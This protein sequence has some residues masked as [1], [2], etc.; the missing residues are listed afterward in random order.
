LYYGKI[1]YKLVI[2][3]DLDY[4]NLMN[5][6]LLY[7]HKVNRDSASKV[8]CHFHDFWQLEIVT[9][10][11]IDAMI[12]GKCF[13]LNSRDM[14]L[15][16][17]GIEHGFVYNFPDISWISL[18]FS[19]AFTDSDTDT[20]TDTNTDTDT[21]NETLPVIDVDDY[22]VIRY[23]PFTGRLI[24]SLEAIVQNAILEDYEKI[25]IEGHIEAI[26]RYIHS[27]SYIH[28]ESVRS[29]IIDDITSFI[30]SCNGKPVTVNEIAKK[31]SYSRS[32][33]SKEFKQQT[34]Q[35]LKSYIDKTRLDKAKEMLLY[36]DFSISDIAFALGF[37]DVY[38]FSRFFKKHAASC[39]KIYR[40]NN[41]FYPSSNFN[42]F[43]QGIYQSY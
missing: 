19:A 22:T 42:T 29:T 4:N 9:G 36:S 1:H 18:K 13:A 27:D 21:G 24:A 8:N 25:V 10:G 7:V 43:L 28:P 3:C 26:L 38:S 30:K 15:I 37:K 14:L 34:G 17:P 23:S 20:N 2:L 6:N 33:I 35:S 31:L 16:R 39:P 40:K 32:H 12:N 5:I 11:C 41:R